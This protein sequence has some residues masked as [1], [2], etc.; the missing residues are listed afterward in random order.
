MP[1]ISAF[2]VSRQIFGSARGSPLL[3]IL[4]DIALDTTIDKAMSSFPFPIPIFKKCVDAIPVDELVVQKFNHHEERLQ[5][6]IENEIK[7]KLPYLDMTDIR[8]ED[9][10]LHT[11][12]FIKPIASRRIL[13]K[14]FFHLPKYKENPASNFIHRVCSLS[15]RLNTTAK[16]PIE[17]RSISSMKE[18]VNQQPTLYFEILDKHLKRAHRHW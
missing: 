1:T 17:Q 4:A 13:N 6:T 8:T 5:S 16:K 7:G 3:P 14:N 15:T 11:E 9:Q 18:S 2:K 10:S 12:W